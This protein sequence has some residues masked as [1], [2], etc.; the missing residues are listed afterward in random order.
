LDLFFSDHLHDEA[1]A[2]L[3]LDLFEI[4]LEHPHLAALRVD[5]GSE[6]DEVVIGGGVLLLP[7]RLEGGRHRL[8]EPFDDRL[9][10]DPF[11]PLQLAQRRDHLGVHERA[12]FSSAAQSGAVRADTMSASSM[13]RGSPSIS[14][15]M[16][17]SSARINAPVWT[18]APSTGTVVFTLT[19]APVAR[20]NCPAV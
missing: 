15:S 7:R 8:L 17:S 4:L 13:R 12:P 3:G 1:L 16:A 11:F 19:R 20:A 14:T 9:E 6:S 2:V 5:L 10:R 18:R